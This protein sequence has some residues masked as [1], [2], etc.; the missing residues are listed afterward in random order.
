MRVRTTRPI[1]KSPVVDRLAFLL[2]WVFDMSSDP[3]STYSMLRRRVEKEMEDGTCKY[4]VLRGS[5]YRMNFRILLSS[6]ETVRVQIGAFDS[7]RKKGDVRVD[8]NPAKFGPGDIDEFH[9]VMRRLIGRRYQGLLR[10]A[11][12]HRVD[13]AVD[14]LNMDLSRTLVSYSHAQRFTMFGKRMNATGKVEGYNFGS[15]TS[16]YTTAVYGK[17]IE[18]V[19]QAL[20]S[21]AKKGANIE[22]LAANNIK[23]IAQFRDA[24]P[25]MRVEVRG[26]K[27]SN[28]P[29]YKLR[30][31][32]NRFE[33]FKFARLGTDSS[34]LPAWLEAS[35][36]S[37]CRERGV[38]AALATF[39]K[40]EHAREVHQFWGT[41]QC[42][43]WQPEQL[44][45]HA[46][47]ALE[48]LGIFPAEAFNPGYIPV[49]Q[50][51][52]LPTFDFGKEPIAQPAISRPSLAKSKRPPQN[53]CR[54]PV[55]SVKQKIPHRVQR[56]PLI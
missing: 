43:W 16:A 29:L 49:E 11:L 9:D 22:P 39:K 48:E 18:R 19:H 4:A 2:P 40:T 6:G 46:C 44:W 33:R 41:R 54:Q 13:F 36:L 37:L 45:Q 35:F 5:R 42:S 53:N 24:P 8:M 7:T 25:T 47:D 51:K 34:D 30:A 23:Q 27:L 50:T 3:N 21:I 55:S 38:K 14:V 17:D 15:V 56:H 28:L 52:E 12:L 32:A 10:K 26:K 20:L 1:P 31:E